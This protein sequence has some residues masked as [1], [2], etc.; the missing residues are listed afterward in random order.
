MTLLLALSVSG[1]GAAT[2]AF[3]SLQIEGQKSLKN[4]RFCFCRCVAVPCDIRRASTVM[5][6]QLRF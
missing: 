5:G 6:D 4:D 3:A 2:E 1:T